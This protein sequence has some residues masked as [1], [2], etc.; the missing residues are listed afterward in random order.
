[1]LSRTLFMAELTDRSVSKEIQ[2]FKEAFEKDYCTPSPGI[3]LRAMDRYH[4]HTS[5]Y[6]RSFPVV[7][8]SGMGKSRLM[9]HS[10]TLR[11]TIPFNIHEKLESGATYPPFDHQ[12]REFLT[13]EF[14]HEVDAITRPLVFLQA[15]FNE[16]VAEL[17]SQKTKITKGTPQEIASK[18][19]EWMKVGSTVDNVGT[20]RTMLYDRVVEKAR[21]L[22][23]EPVDHQKLL[24]HRAKALRTAAQSL[25]DCLKKLY[26]TEVEFCA[27]VYFDEAHTLS[28]PSN[29]SHR[30]TPYYA[31][32]RVL[33]MI[34][35]MQIFFVFLSTNSS[36]LTFAPLASKAVYPA[37]IRVQNNTE[38]IPPFFEL[39]FDTFCRKFTSDAKEV[40]KLTLEGV[41]DLGQMTKFGRPMWH[42]YYQ[43][44]PEDE[45][46]KMIDLAVLKLRGNDHNNADLAAL[47][48][49]VLIP[50]DPYQLV[51]RTTEVELVR[52]HMRC[53]YNIP[54]DRQFV[55]SAYLSEPVLSEAAAVI[56]NSP[57]SNVDPGRSIVDEAPRI[58]ANALETGLLA[59]EER[60]QLIARTLLTVA[61]DGA[62]KLDSSST[63]ELRYHRPIRLVHFLEKLLSPEVWKLVRQATPVHV[64]RDDPELEVAFA[65]T[66]VNF[67]HFTRLGDRKSYNL[68][69]A[70]ELLKRGAAMQTYNK[71]D[72]DVGI[73]L[74]NGDLTSMISVERTS[75]AQFQVLNFPRRITVSPNP[76]LIGE[77]HDDLPILS[78]SMQLGVEKSGVEIM[79]T[80]I[81]GDAPAGH[82]VTRSVLAD[83]E[84]R[85]YSIVLYGCTAATYSCIGDN[86][87]RYASLL[88]IPTPFQN[89]LRKTD[90]ELLDTVH[91]LSHQVV[92]T[93]WKN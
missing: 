20:N 52:S 62:A 1:M 71:Q 8:S 6:N 2:Y 81:D 73:P 53:I 13:K 27:I 60:R 44:L 59:Q 40:G 11:F 17:Q 33:N 39:R 45:K 93:V 51:S 85:H 78:V 12:V 88:R 24:E 55:R 30:R 16:T 57:R 82:T 18:W 32:M 63:F 76:S 84:R 15:L 65:N 75:I 14:K 5:Y 64:Y 3:L 90:P 68:E 41:C 19:Y 31:L 38:L 74:H 49:R 54:A 66:W 23:R 35:D 25:V 83:I 72:Q 29:K 21:E 70:S 48:S 42:S 26:K 10:A 87:A 67:S 86:A 22:E 89:Y 92:D 47:D 58:L 37:P 34:N 4:T 69:F 77:C 28:L 50:F 36:L 91:T 56:L 79:T 9:D 43:S 61:H 7:Q 46:H 80:Q